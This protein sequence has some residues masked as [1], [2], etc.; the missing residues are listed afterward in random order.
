MNSNDSHIWICDNPVSHQ[1]LT[2]RFYDTTMQSSYHIILEFRSDAQCWDINL[3]RDN[4]EPDGWSQWLSPYLRGFYSYDD[5]TIL[6]IDL[7][8]GLRI[9]FPHINGWN[10]DFHNDPVKPIEIHY[11]S[12]LYPKEFFEYFDYDLTKDDAPF[13][14]HTLGDVR[15]LRKAPLF[16]QRVAII[17][18]RKPDSLGVDVA[19]RLGSY[20]SSEIVVSGLALG[21]DT[22]A[23]RGCVD[24]GGRTIAVVGSGLGRVHPKENV[25]LQN[26]IIRSGGLIVSEQEDNTKANPRTLIARTRI[27]MAMAD[28]VIVVECERESGTMHAVRFARRFGKPIFALDCGWSG[29]RYLIDNKIAQP[30]R[31]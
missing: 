10:D 3:C 24:A 11:L 15:L 1:R 28:K 20:H 22:A 21:V 23:H 30:F 12:P 5:L 8:T 9:R 14:L 6:K 27:Q 4:G 2:Y 25:D 19:Y 29:N 7:I 31:I 26:D 16:E 13:R 18:S 17:G